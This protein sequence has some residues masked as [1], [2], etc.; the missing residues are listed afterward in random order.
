LAV[1]APP[2]L[3][4]RAQIQELACRAAQLPALSAGLPGQ[5]G[6]SVQRLRSAFQLNR[7]QAQALLEAL[8][9]AELL[10][11]AADP[12]QPWRHPRPLRTQDLDEIRACLSASQATGA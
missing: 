8:E 10:L 9:Q 7:P 12:R 4:E 2:P 3:L 5:V 1:A 6:L 11:P